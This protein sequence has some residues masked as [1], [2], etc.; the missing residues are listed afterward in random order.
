MWFTVTENYEMFVLKKP[1]QDLQVA[2]ALEVAWH[3][4]VKLH[5]HSVFKNSVLHNSIKRPAML[6]EI[7]FL[8]PSSSF[9][10]ISF[11]AA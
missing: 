10:H 9:P 5:F 11:S 1:P 3:V 7:F 8:S 4:D 2:M 6:A